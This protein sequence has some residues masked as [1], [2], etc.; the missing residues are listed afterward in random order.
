[1]KK[2]RILMWAGSLIFL[3][4]LYLDS[5]TDFPKYVSPPFLLIGPAFTLWDLHE[6]RRIPQ[7]RKPITQKA[8]HR[9]FALT[10]TALIIGSILSFF[11]NSHSNLNLSLRTELLIALITLVSC[12]GFLY[13]RIYRRPM[14]VDVN[15]FPKRWLVLAAIGILFF[16]FAEVFAVLDRKNEATRQ[17]DHLLGDALNASQNKPPGVERGEELVRRLRAIDTHRAPADVQ[18]AV[19]EYTKVLDDALALYKS[20][21]EAAAATIFDP[22][23]ATKKEALEQ[24]IKKYR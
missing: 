2:A 6:S 22:I 4:G 11:L 15:R 7:N 14:E 24:A 17:V 10:V 20:G 3:T 18:V 13:W 9:I 19:S 5:L 8:R 21:R 12:G 23:I 1:M 16:I